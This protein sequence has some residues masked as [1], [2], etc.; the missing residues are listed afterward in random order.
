[1]SFLRSLLL[2][3]GSGRT[4]PLRKQCVITNVTTESYPKE[5][6]ETLLS[7]KFPSDM[8]KSS[9]MSFYGDLPF[10]ISYKIKGQKKT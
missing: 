5:Q 1:M 7:V 8:L 3:E 4:R 6:Q 10:L 2:D 9:T